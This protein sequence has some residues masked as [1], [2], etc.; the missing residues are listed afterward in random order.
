MVINTRNGYPGDMAD[1]E[2]TDLGAAAESDLQ[3]AESD[4]HPADPVDNMRTARF[5][6]E[7]A[8]AHADTSDDTPTPTETH[9]D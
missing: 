2:S 3:R 7:S 9:A 5:G 6:R 1:T 4:L 8:A